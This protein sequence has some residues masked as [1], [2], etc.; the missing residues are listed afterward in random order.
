M[1]YGR[2][3]TH[4]PIEALHLWKSARA[5]RPYSRKRA[6]RAFRFI[7]HAKA[8]TF[9]IK[10]LNKE[11]VFES[12]H[13]SRWFY[14]PFT[15]SDVHYDSRAKRLFENGCFPKQKLI[16][17]LDSDLWVLL[18]SYA[19]GVR[20]PS[21]G[22]ERSGKWFRRNAITC[23]HNPLWEGGPYKIFRHG[24][25]PALLYGEPHHVVWCKDCFT[26]YAKRRRRLKLSS[27]DYS[28]NKR[29][30]EAAA[31]AWLS[32]AYLKKPDRLNLL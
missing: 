18:Y 2:D 15:P 21:C 10:V 31:I 24:L 8:N 3:G 27:E 9:H 1:I 6:C 5:L 30:S 23:A 4:S 29:A 7:N 22:A 11:Y 26:G 14:I 20:C 28:L 19:N 13:R 16:I 12:G 17:F 25:M 32:W